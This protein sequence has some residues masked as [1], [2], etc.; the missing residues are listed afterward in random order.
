MTVPLKGIR[1][2][3]EREYNNSPLKG[4]TTTVPLKGIQQQSL[5]REYNNS[6]LNGNTTTVP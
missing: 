4:N 3:L 1:Q 2:S 5:E 6:P